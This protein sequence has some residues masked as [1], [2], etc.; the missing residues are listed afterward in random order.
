MFVDENGNFIPG[1]YSACL[2]AKESGGSRVVTPISTSQ[3]VDHIERKVYRTKVGSPYVIEKMKEN[4]IRYGFEPNGGAIFS[5]IMLTRDA[6]AT[7][8]KLLN[9]LKNKNMKLN[10]AIAELPKFY[11][12]KDKVDYKWE[13][14][15]KILS[16]AKKVFR[17]IKKDERDG[18][19]IWID[20]TSWILFRSSQN[21]PEFRIFA[22]SENEHKAKELFNEGLALV[23]RLT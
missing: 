23:K 19:K 20:K 2:I 6:G 16:E 7:T 12:F 14:Q 15:E 10:E 18:I 13:L 8:I 5:E 9:I 22:E 3:V 4:N 11:S 17:G 1:D 21:A